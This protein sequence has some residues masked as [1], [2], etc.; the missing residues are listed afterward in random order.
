MVLCKKTIMNIQVTFKKI[1][2]DREYSK[3]VI[4][5]VLS[6]LLVAVQSFGFV[7]S[8]AHTLLI[9]IGHMFFHAGY[10]LSFLIVTL[11]KR[12]DIAIKTKNVDKKIYWTSL[13]L[14]IL[15]IGWR[16]Y[17]FF[18][19]PFDDIEHVG[20]VILRIV[21]GISLILIWIQTYILHESRD[22][23]CSI[24]C[25][26]ARGHLLIDTVALMVLFLLS[27]LGGVGLRF[28]DLFLFPIIG[29]S[30]IVLII[31][32]PI[33]DWVQLFIKKRKNNHE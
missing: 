21:V 13:I 9:G 27:F 32:K 18:Y 30:I 22:F 3:I 2:T 20:I 10:F 7:H 29:I 28:F 24:M 23:T 8:H 12:G 25:H 17:E 16:A 6:S 31:T 15:F 14:V 33:K 5:L 11:I 26:G 4:V 19:H 1:F